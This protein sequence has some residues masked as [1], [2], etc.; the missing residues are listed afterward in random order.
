M[1]I[2]ILSILFMLVIIIRSYKYIDNN[3]V[4]SNDLIKAI[5]PAVIGIFC[6]TF[7]ATY[8]AL[9]DGGMVS[10]EYV[11]YRNIL[12]AIFLAMMGYVIRAGIYG[13]VFIYRKGN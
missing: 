5:V 11:M 8:F 7:R 10:S 13:A 2:I 3:T 9:P 1:T 12:M 4:T 6:L